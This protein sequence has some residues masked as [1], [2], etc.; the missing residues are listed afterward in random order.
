MLLQLQAGSTC[1]KKYDS[2]NNLVL[3]RMALR[4]LNVC[5]QSPAALA[6]NP[7]LIS[8]PSSPQISSSTP[9][10]HLAFSSAI[11]LAPMG[12]HNRKLSPE[13]DRLPL[14]GR[15]SFTA[16]VWLGGCSCM[17]SCTLGSRDI[18][19]YQPHKDVALIEVSTFYCLH[20]MLQWNTAVV[21]PPKRRW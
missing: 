7:L 17:N 16:P 10:L 20:F 14:A 5:K 1:H 13:W 2:C 15:R 9:L 3:M 12:T 21:L 6:P 4:L 19:V 18:C 8:S 11:P